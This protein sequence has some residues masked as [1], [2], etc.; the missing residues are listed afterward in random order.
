MHF[1]WPLLLTFSMMQEPVPPPPDRSGEAELRQIM[2]AMGSLRDVA[3]LVDVHSR[4]HGSAPLFWSKGVRF[5]FA[6]KYRYRAYHMDGWGDGKLII[7]NGKEL[8]IDSL[9]FTQ[10]VILKTATDK[11]WEDESNLAAGGDQATVLFYLLNGEAVFDE[12]VGKDGSVSLIDPAGPLKGVKVQGKPFGEVTILYEESDKSMLVRSIAYDNWTFKENLHKRWPEWV[13]PPQV[14]TLDL[15]LVTYLRN[16]RFGKNWFSTA[17]PKGMTLDDRRK[18]DEQ[19]PKDPVARL[20]G[21]AL[22]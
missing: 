15:E 22:G 3:I 20:Q 2:R 8:L 13:D 5:D 7:R 12:L 18:K 21:K 19:P 4:E 9:D 11:F 6:G 14:G 17:T 1:A 10:S 16:A